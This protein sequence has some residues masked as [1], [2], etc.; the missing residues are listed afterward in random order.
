MK[1]LFPL[2]ALVT[3]PVLALTQT[4]A[5]APASTSAP[6]PV[7]EKK[8]SAAVPPAKP[9]IDP[10]PAPADVIAA[11]KKAALFYRNRT[12]VVGGYGFSVPKD[13]STSRAEDRE[14]PTMVSIQPPGTPSVGLAFLMA[15]KVTKDP[16]FQQAAREAAQSL[17]WCQLASG[18]WESEYDYNPA[19]ARRYHYRRDV[20]ASDTER[21][22]RHGSSTLD[23]GKTEAALLFLLE[24]AHTPEFA[25]DEELQRGVKFGFD[26]L[27][28]AQEKCGA[29]GQSFDGPADASAPV[30]KARLPAQWS[31]TF[32]AV[33]YTKF[34]TLNDGNLL[35]TTRLLLR[36]YE[37]TK[38]A[39]YLDAAKR[40][41]DFHLLAQLPAPQPAWAQQYN[42]NMEPVWARKFEPPAVSSAES[43]EALETLLELWVAT[44]EAKYR[45]PM[46]AA[47]AWLD[48]VK[49]PDGQW[50][51]FYELA[52][53]KPLYCK[54]KTYE[55]TYDDSDLP[56]HYG[57]KLDELGEDLE[58]LKKKL[59]MSREELQHAKAE[60]TEP[61]KWA[62][63]AKGAA[64]K[65]VTALEN[66]NPKG[67]WSKDN[68][69]DMGEF[70]KH[71]RALVF[72]LEGAQKGGEFFEKLRVGK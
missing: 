8:P 39:R 56:T 13:L 71:M 35:Q 51:R 62:S 6:A 24:M 38:E 28:A 72:Y 48:K 26:G 9:K 7:P 14:S 66:L 60:P 34:Y 3:A 10:F 70:V 5:P 36:A 68:Q 54:A 46:A 31:R 52:T 43:I 2:V 29:W 44:G 4:A 53:D 42:R 45:E 25:Q 11:M 67:Y 58:M 49:L 33:D 50:A 57:F 20:E 32:P 55:V 19:V 40:V 37:L 63:K 12:S 18:G 59:A 64:K 22:G 30:V 27:L 1:C 47:I 61:K 17:L 23:D 16:L 15:F 65:V 69:I 21:G 41:G